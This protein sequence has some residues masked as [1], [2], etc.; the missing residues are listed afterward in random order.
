MRIGQAASRAGV[1]VETVRFY[2]HKG[3]IEQPP[4]PHGGGYRD[5]PAE[6]VRRIKFVRRAQ[7]IGFS[8][9]E[10]SELLQLQARRDTDCADVRARARAKRAEVQAKID[11]LAK[12]G[13]ALDGLIA[14]CPGAGPVA[15]CSIMEAITSGALDLG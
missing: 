13:E 8:L 3:L 5:Y 1:G 11:D 15:D 6:T 14:A 7:Q 9:A 2:E 10:I 12:I 4:R